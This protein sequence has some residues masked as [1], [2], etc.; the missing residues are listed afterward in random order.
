M[1][2]YDQAADDLGWEPRPMKRMPAVVSLVYDV[3]QFEMSD[4]TVEAE[5]NNLRSQG[6]VVTDVTRKYDPRIGHLTEYW[7]W[8]KDDYEF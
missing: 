1:N 7:G 6:F 3:S 5:K 2:P 4:W 8:H